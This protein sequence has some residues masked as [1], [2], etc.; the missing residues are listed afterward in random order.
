MII[1]D[2][3]KNL[4]FGHGTC[5]SAYI[6]VLRIENFKVKVPYKFSHPV[7]GDALLGAR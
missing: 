6:C 4:N 2:H 5:V 7:G 3:K 1:A